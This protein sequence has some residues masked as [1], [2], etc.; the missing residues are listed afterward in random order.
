MRSTFALIIALITCGVLCGCAVPALQDERTGEVA[1]EW[2]P[3]PGGAGGPWSPSPLLPAKALKLLPPPDTGFYMCNGFDDAGPLTAHAVISGSAGSAL[4]AYG[5]WHGLNAGRLP[6]SSVPFSFG[7][8]S[9][10]KPL[11][12]CSDYPPSC[13]GLYC[14]FASTVPDELVWATSAAEAESLTDGI[15]QRFNVPQF[16]PTTCSE[17]AEPSEQVWSCIWH[18]GDGTTCSARATSEHFAASACLARCAGG[19]EL[20]AA[21]CQGDWEGPE[22][23]SGP[24]PWNVSCEPSEDM[25]L[26]GDVAEQMGYLWRCRSW[27]R[28][29]VP[30]APEPLQHYQWLDSIAFGGGEHPDYDRIRDWG[31]HLIETGK[32]RYGGIPS[33]YTYH[34]KPPRVDNTQCCEL[35]EATDDCEWTE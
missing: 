13:G 15:R 23:E 33:L 19:L 12:R 22:P 32:L 24:S 18:K 1:Q 31:A 9:S 26:H 35:D 20:A 6:I 11:W 17:L 28:T 25:L 16:F 30:G 34:V 10:G 7:C 21:T 5:L 8:A 3:W 4:V 27:A 2:I 29:D 14:L